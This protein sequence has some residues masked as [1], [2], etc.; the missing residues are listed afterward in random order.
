MNAKTTELRSSHVPF[1]SHPKE[2]AKSSKQRPADDD[3]YTAYFNFLL[4]AAY[5]FMF[6][7]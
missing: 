7:H 5:T 1:L 6:S 4:A 3:R 2:V